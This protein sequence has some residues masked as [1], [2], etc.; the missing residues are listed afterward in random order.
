MRWPGRRRCWGVHP[1]VF[2]TTNQRSCRPA[3][4]DAL[5]EQATLLGIPSHVPSGAA[6]G[7]SSRLYTAEMCMAPP[8]SSHGGGM[9]SVHRC[10]LAVCSQGVASCFQPSCGLSR[11]LPGCDALQT[12]SLPLHSAPS[13]MLRPAVPP[14]PFDVASSK[15]D[16]CG[17]ITRLLHLCPPRS[18]LIN[19]VGAGAGAGAFRHPGDRLKTILNCIFCFKL[20]FLTAVQR[21]DGQRRAAVVAGARAVAGL[22]RG[23]GAG[24]AAG[25]GLLRPRLPRHLPQR[26]G[27]RQ[28]ALDRCLVA[29]RFTSVGI[30]L[31]LQL[32]RSTRE[33]AALPDGRL[34]EASKTLGKGSFARPCRGTYHGEAVKVRI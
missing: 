11:L 24:A 34:L 4:K 5:D 18:V 7:A 13:K 17:R 27:S 26:G 31:K 22:L 12:P 32:K 28:G 15:P 14:R 20:Y 9:N 19:A 23:P 21:A 30:T 33:A 10:A 2:L 29:C 1:T 6:G 25:Q 8:P 16:G 3:A